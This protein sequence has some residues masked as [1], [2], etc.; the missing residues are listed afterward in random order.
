M[1]FTATNTITPHVEINFL[2]LKK[3]VIG[4]SLHTLHVTETLSGNGTR[5]LST[6]FTN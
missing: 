5:K 6:L 1:E 4:G 3:V 2:M